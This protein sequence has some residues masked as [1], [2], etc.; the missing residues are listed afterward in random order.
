MQEVVLVTGASSGVGE[1]LAPLLAKRGYWVFGM[2]RREV[3]LAGVTALPADVS[4]PEAVQQAIDQLI[5]E[6]GRL[7]AVLHCAGIGGAGPV[8]QMPTDRARRIMDTNFWGSWNLCQA[9]LPHLRKAPRGR[10]LLVGSIA[11]F[12]GI[13]FRSAYCASKAALRTLTDSL[14][15][16]L[17][18]TSLQVT[19]VCPGDIATNS[20]ATQYRQPVEELAPIYQSSY[21]KADDGMAANVDH[22]MDAQ[23]VAERMY[24]IMN[25]ENLKPNYVIGA[26]IQKA[27]TVAS[28][29][30]PGRVWEWV[31][32][33]YYS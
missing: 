15:M 20:I 18:G 24:V 19:C 8:E 26:P 27:S 25:Q 21:K 16:E 29:I 17:K 2:S 30:L 9:T 33:K 3:D 32:G 6:T 7:D 14:R 12:M 22:G 23:K 13:P 31:L 1:A 5:A 28:R 4:N 11:G 10:L